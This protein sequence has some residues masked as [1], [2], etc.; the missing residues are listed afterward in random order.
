MAVTTRRSNAR[1][2]PGR[3]VLDNQ[4]TRRTKEQVQ[5]AK[6]HAKEV[7]DKE[8]SR[9]RALPGRIAQLE[10]EI[11]T[12]EQARREHSMRPDLRGVQP[13]DRRTSPQSP[14]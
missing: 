8:E 9:R 10:D 12:E 14:G 6:A 4:R 13:S 3:V 1:A 11:E 2:H 7:K 5:E